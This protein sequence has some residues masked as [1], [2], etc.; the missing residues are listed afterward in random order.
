[1]SIIWS[2]I[3]E[4]GTIVPVQ[5]TAEGKVVA[6]GD[7]PQGEYLPTSGGQLTGPL[8]SSSTATFEGQIETTGASY[9]FADGTKQSSAAV[10]PLWA[11][12]NSGGDLQGNS[13]FASVTAINGFQYE[14][15]FITPKTNNLYAVVVTSF[16]GGGDIN[17]DCFW[18]TTSR[19]NT[20]FI[21]QSIKYNQDGNP[22]SAGYNG[23]TVMVLGFEMSLFFKEQILDR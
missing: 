13:G 23:H 3:T 11:S 9:K 20:G 2:G 7:G 4:D 19:F 6:V 14:Y 1:M 12:T 15:E 5:V 17:G 21:I 18:K 10:T 16:S 22:V 8:T